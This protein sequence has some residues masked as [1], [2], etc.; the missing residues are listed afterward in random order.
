MGLVLGVDTSYY[1]T[2]LALVDSKKL[3][4]DRRAT[5]EV[6]AGQRG[7][8]QSRAVFQHIKNFPRL[9]EETGRKYDLSKLEA[10]AASTRPR[11]LE[12]S[13]MPVFNVSEGIGRTLAACFQIPFVK[14]SHQEGHIMA[15]L[16]SSGAELL[17]CFLVVHIS[18]G[19]SE[20]LKVSS[21]EDGK[22]FGIELLAATQD[23]YAGQFIDRIGV[24]LGL[25]FPSGPHLEKL[26]ASH[27]GEP[28]FIPFA[29]KGK[30]FSFSGP[31]TC[32]RRLF[33]EG[34]PA[35][36]IAASVQRCIAVTLEKV[37][38]H[39]IEETRLL[40]ILFVGGVASNKYLMQR[41][42]FRLEH[43]A[44]GAKLYF[45]EPQYSR[46]NAVGVALIGSNY[47]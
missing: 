32:A 3:I 20:V 35:E 34:I 6:P 15:G 1:T 5:L 29:V 47:Y 43:R 17:N 21:D 23:L 14:T 46:D 24:L 2:S 11:P 36:A 30:S 19:T 10:V 7:M 25:P 4:E 31:E 38:L 18:G 22:S 33:Q 16:W 42:R 39:V 40:E 37:L 9:I 28:V 27:K 45:A 44:V 12:K 26:A 41:L 13:Y 8:R